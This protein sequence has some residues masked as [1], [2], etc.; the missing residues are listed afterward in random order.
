MAR[1]PIAFRSNESKYKFLGSP[2]LVNCY[3]EKQGEDTKGVLAV[4]PSAGIVQHASVIEGPCRGMIY[5]KDIDALYSVHPSAIYRIYE[6]GNAV[7]VGTVP[8]T[9]NV[10]LSRNQKETPQ[11]TILSNIGLQCLESD[12]VTYITD[13][14]LPSQDPDN[15]VPCI[16]QDYVASRNIF[17]FADRRFFWSAIDSVKTVDALDYDAFDQYAGSLVRVKG[18]G[19]QLFGFCSG[20]L[21]VYNPSG[22]AEA[23]FDLIATRQ[24]GLLAPHAVQSFDN[25]LIFPGDDRVIYRLDNYN[26]VRVSIHAVE[27]LLKADTSPAEMVSFCWSDEGHAFANFTGDRYSVCY[28]A[29]TQVWH[30]RESHNLPKWRVRHSVK[31]WN[32]TFVGDAYS[33]RIGYLDGDT[34]TEYGG[35]MVW[36]VDSPTLD[37]FP[38]GAIVDAV[39]FDLATG[40]GLVGMAS[41]G[42]DPKIM[43]WVS[44]DGGNTFD[45]YRELELGKAGKYQAR[46][47]AR[48]LGKCGP[49]GMVFRLRI[50]DPVVRSLVSTD[51]EVRRLKK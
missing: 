38:D 42:H 12:S 3:A 17:G 36:G 31:A 15:P 48:R 1:V 6:N 32:K 27:R 29:A 35:P 11:V 16:T 51:V 50:S 34:F 13:P 20:W 37:T 5:L 26:P 18:D 19:G 44:R 23:P 41:Q 7:R 47:T 28:D 39:H 14:D 2:K 49:Q 10:Q 4:L 24:R 33:G 40:Y 30:S 22:P 9:D 43:L 46:V 8:G 21:E 45:I 25:T